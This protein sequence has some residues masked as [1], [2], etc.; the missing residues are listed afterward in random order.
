MSAYLIPIQTALIVF[1]LLAVILTIPYIIHQYRTY[2]ATLPLRILI[3]FSFIFYL[4]CCYFLVSL[5]LP[6]IDEVAQYTTP[7]MQ[8]IPFAS[9]KDITLTTS[10]VWDD[11]STYLK[12]LNEPSVLQVL[13][14]ILM[15]IPFGIYL[16]YYFNVTFKKTLLFSFLLSLSFECLQLSGL[17]FV[18]P[19][20]YRLFDVDDLITNTLGGV[21][22][23]GV[24]PLMEH[25]LPSREQLDEKSYQKGMHV[26]AVRRMFAFTIDLIITLALFFSYLLLTEKNPYDAVVYL[27]I[28]VILF[29]VLPCLSKGRTLGKMIVKIRLVSINDTNAK[30]YQYLL[31][32]LPTYLGII[33][34]PYIVLFFVVSFMDTR[35]PML[36]AWYAGFALYLAFY[37]FYFFDA[38]LSLFQQKENI[39]DKISKVKN[40]STIRIREK[41]E[42]LKP[43]SDKNESRLQSEEIKE[44]THS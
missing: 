19:R 10:L 26:T 28:I 3:V 2:G 9:L 6:P 32:F 29:V 4:L 16:R 42:D 25:M 33:P 18:Y 21:I 30:W 8:L 34:F 12:A 1:P 17:L 43:I 38:L 20:P 24:S 40:S 7:K 5:P 31:H 22:G 14:N 44:D 41:A 13:F 15:S 27:M 36:Y 11:P 23:Y 39:Y 35:A 37:L